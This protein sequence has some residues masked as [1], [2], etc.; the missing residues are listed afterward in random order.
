MARQIFP[1]PRLFPYSSFLQRFV[2]KNSHAASWYILSPLGFSGATLI[3]YDISGNGVLLLNRKSPL[4]QKGDKINLPIDNVIFKWVL[5]RGRWEEHESNFLADHVNKSSSDNIVFIDIGGQAGLVSRQFF[6]RLNRP[7][8]NAWIVEPFSAHI[9]AIENNCEKWIANGVLKIFPYALDILESERWLHIQN[10]NSGNASLIDLFS[11]TRHS[12]SYPVHAKS[13]TDFEKSMSLTASSVFLKCDIQGLDS[14]VLS[15]FSAEFWS[16]VKCCVI[17]IW[18]IE[19]IEIT[20]VEVLMKHWDQFAIL[21]WDPIG[22]RKCTLD[23]VRNFWL[24]KS[25]STRNLYISM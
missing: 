8:S 5:R 2:E 13:V 23:E 16:Q 15:L 7:I 17:E 24:S 3:S 14:K 11:G 22:E 20:D 18:A 9:T 6:L 19:A 1:F 4:G 25:G 10:T 12:K 21:S